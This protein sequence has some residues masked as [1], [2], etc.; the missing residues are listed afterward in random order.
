MG[1]TLPV[2]TAMSVGYM[3]HYNKV[4]LQRYESFAFHHAVGINVALNNFRLFD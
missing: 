2:G 3:L 1:F 4:N